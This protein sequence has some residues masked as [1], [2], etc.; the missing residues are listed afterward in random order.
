MNSI[1]L[2]LRHGNNN[3]FIKTLS[4]TCGRVVPWTRERCF[5][6]P[7]SPQ[8]YMLTLDT[9][10]HELVTEGSIAHCLSWSLE[11]WVGSMF[12]VQYFCKNLEVECSQIATENQNGR[13]TLQIS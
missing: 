6:F 2:P 8:Q 3:I 7:I 9:P 11:S 13:Q 10:G 12:D 4:R 1:V 5:F